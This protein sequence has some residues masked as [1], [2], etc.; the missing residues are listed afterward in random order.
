[1]LLVIDVQ[2]DLASNPQTEIP[3]ASTL[4]ATLTT[5]LERA[6]AVESSDL[7][8]VFVQHH[9]SPS[10]GPLQRGSDAWQLVFPPERP[11][12]ILVH[13]D[14]GRGLSSSPFSFVRS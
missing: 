10:S 6:R 9:E 4:R 12:E 2:R 5:V 1:M 11:G 14:T 8:L 3:S 7:Q 13:K